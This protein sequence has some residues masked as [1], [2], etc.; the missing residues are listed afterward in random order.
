MCRHDPTVML[1]APLRTLIWQHA[2]GNGR[3]TFDQPSVEIRSFGDAAIATVG[4]SSTASSPRCW[5][6]SASTFQRYS[7]A[8]DNTA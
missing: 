4:W 5:T 1:Y 6:I 3:F 7:A 2:D 8:V